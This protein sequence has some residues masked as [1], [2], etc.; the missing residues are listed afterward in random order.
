VPGLV[1][2]LLAAMVQEHERAAGAWHAE[3]ETLAELLRLAGGAAARTRDLLAGLRIDADRMRHNLDAA[4]GSLMA[5]AVAARLAGGLGRSV[6][7]DLV[8]RLVGEARTR[9]APLRDIL[10]ADP[11]VRGQLSTSDIDSA[12]D[13]RHHL[14]AA[15][16]FVTRALAAHGEQP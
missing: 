10:R 16:V 2:T 14:G 8:A 6:A 4:G 7:H 12:L 15:D 11:T 13:P 5:E 1:A 9:G 3:W